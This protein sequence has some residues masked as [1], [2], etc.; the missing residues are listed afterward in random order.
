MSVCVC[1]CVCVCVFVCVRV[2][3]CERECVCVCVCVCVYVRTRTSLC[4]CVCVWLRMFAYI[5]I[6]YTS[7]MFVKRTS[8]E[9]PYLQTANTIS[10]EVSI[11]NGSIIIDSVSPAKRA[12]ESVNGTQ[13]FV[14]RAQKCTQRGS[15]YF[16]LKIDTATHWNKQKGPTIPWPVTSK[17]RSLK[18]SA[19]LLSFSPK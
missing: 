6:W 13:V 8:A 1:M 16:V 10:F 5:H 12:I 11:R 15:K 14:K 9:E 7:V 3:S 17:P 18:N 2:L 4:V 19:V